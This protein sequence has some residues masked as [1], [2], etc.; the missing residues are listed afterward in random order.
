MK[1]QRNDIAVDLR[2]GH[3]VGITGYDH[4]QDAAHIRPVDRI[5]LVVNRRINRYVLMPLP[6]KS[7]L[8]GFKM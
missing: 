1:M 6:K 4:R 3:A 2:N 8:S 5:G 7:F